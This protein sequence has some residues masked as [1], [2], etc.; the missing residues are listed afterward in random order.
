IFE[1]DTVIFKYYVL[2]AEDKVHTHR[3]L[4]E[5]DAK[6]IGDS[7]GFLPFDIEKKDTLLV[8]SVYVDNNKHVHW[9]VFCNYK[10][11]DIERIIE[12]LRYSGMFMRDERSEDIAR[13]IPKSSNA[14]LP[15]FHTYLKDNKIFYEI[16]GHNSKPFFTLS[17]S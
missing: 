3:L 10:W 16:I 2:E 6:Q 11:T 5:D 17:L 12:Y 13:N 1:E 7:L 9:N 15:Y 14:F 4:R 8:R